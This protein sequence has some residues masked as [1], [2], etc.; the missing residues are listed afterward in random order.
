MTL[1]TDMLH[2]AKQINQNARISTEEQRIKERDAL[3]AER[4]STR[5]G[6][7]CKVAAVADSRGYGEGRNM[8]D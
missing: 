5:N 4:V 8:G 6:V 3:F 1:M 2:A 7:K